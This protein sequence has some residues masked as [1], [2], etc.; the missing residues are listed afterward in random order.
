MPTAC[1][2]LTCLLVLPPLFTACSSTSPVGPPECRAGLTACG[3][4]CVD[5]TQSDAHCGACDTACGATQACVKSAC[6]ARDC[7]GADCSPSQV[8]PSE[9][10]VERAC[11]GVVCPTG[12]ACLGGICLS[13]ACTTGDCA[14][15]E[16]C[17]NNACVDGAC[18]GVVCP[19]GDVCRLGLCQAATC[20][21]GLVSTAEPDVDC[22]GACPAKCRE[23]QRCATSSDCDTAN[24][25]SGRCGSATHCTS[26]AKDG[27]ETDVDCG[28]TCPAKCRAGQG[29]SAPTDCQ[30]GGCAAGVCT[31][32]NTCADTQRNGAETDVDCG[33]PDCVARCA[34]DGGCGAHTDCQSGLCTAGKCASASCSDTNHNGDETGVDCGGP[35]CPLR[36][37]TGQG[38]RVGN[39]CLDYVCDADA[40]VCLPPSC[41]DFARNGTE[42]DED[43]GGGCPRRCTM[44]QRCLTGTDCTSGLCLGSLCAADPSCVDGIKNQ[45]EVDVDC[46][47]SCS[48]C[49][50]GQSCNAPGDCA[51]FVCLGTPGT[52]RGAVFA[53]PLTSAYSSGTNGALLVTGHVNADAYPDL[54]LNPRNGSQPSVVFLGSASGQPSAPTPATSTSA[55]GG[56]LFGIALV[57]VNGDGL[58]DH[59]SL[60]SLNALH[61]Y[62]SNGDGTFQAGYQLPATPPGAQ[63]N[64]VLQ[65]A[66]LQGDGRPDVC[67]AYYDFTGGTRRVS[68]LL[69]QGDG[70]LS[71]PTSTLVG[72][73]ANVYPYSLVVGD[74]VRDGGV[75][76]AVGSGAGL[77][78]TSGEVRVL[79]GV[80]DGTF[81]ASAA[82]TTV[83]PLPE[84]AVTTDFNGDGKADLAVMGRGATS[85][86]YQVLLGDAQAGFS[87]GPASAAAFNPAGGLFCADYNRDGKA[88]L[89]AVQALPLQPVRFGLGAGTFQA[90]PDGPW[91]GEVSVQYDANLD[92]KP[93]VAVWT[94]TELRVYLGL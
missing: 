75:D 43:C 32:A 71:A 4:E 70:G 33:G 51:S 5:L 45:G 61:V 28:G 31:Q 15:G 40:G 80:G 14:L 65:T 48:R 19:S 22:G 35:T 26:G 89:L 74:F 8:C 9:A 17:V 7:A 1:L 86:G 68:V 88:D 79:S 18:Q 90:G 10:C 12:Q 72:S 73:G 37:P 64:Y 81:I 84:K 34:D 6:Y 42:S 20:M 58:D 82:A 92:G 60:G 2:R 39:D 21:D 87:A 46:G 78:A 66:D 25:A 63:T 49:A 69:N 3:A 57:D 62:L 76:L 77:A 56:N 29:C 36:C 50:T 27:D 11:L 53:P 91:A 30:T 44:G 13:S 59:L 54:V 52:C 24:C 16:A 47:G 83:S 67:I 55:F 93:D 41:T 94:R 23:G 85:T 38:C